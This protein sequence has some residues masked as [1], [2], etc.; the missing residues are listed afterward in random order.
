MD[1][2]E[3]NNA[4]IEENQ[5]TSFQ[6]SMDDQVSPEEAMGISALRAQVFS[7]P[8]ADADNNTTST[9]SSKTDDTIHIAGLTLLFRGNMPM[10]QYW[11]HGGARKLTAWSTTI[12]INNMPYGHYTI[13]FFDNKGSHQPWPLTAASVKITGRMHAEATK[14]VENTCHW[15]NPEPSIAPIELTIYA[16]TTWYHEGAIP[17]PTQDALYYKCFVGN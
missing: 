9:I 5:D 8:I 12:T 16:E 13:A 6:F 1:T 2:K 4:T 7:A 17:R 3:N 14:L 15:L 11:R 10:V